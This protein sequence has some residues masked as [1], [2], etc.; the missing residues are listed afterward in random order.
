VRHLLF[1]LIFLQVAACESCASPLTPR[2]PIPVADAGPQLTPPPAPPPTPHPVVVVDAGPPPAPAW[3]PGVGEACANI[4][5]VGC[6]EG[7]SN[8]P[9]NL[10]RAVVKRLTTVPLA[11]LATAKSKAAVRA[12]GSFVACP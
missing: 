4:R 8:C 7:G 9:S 12:C 11:C 2:P 6:A 1:G 3:A 10:Q 5:A